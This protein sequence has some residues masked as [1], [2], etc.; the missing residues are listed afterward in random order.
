MDL[1]TSEW[2]DCVSAGGVP[3][4]TCIW[5]VLQNLINALIVLSGVVAVF[6][7]MYAGYQYLTSQGDQEKVQA[8]RKTLTFTIIGL[9][10]VVFAFFILR[11]IVIFTGVDLDQLTTPP[12]PE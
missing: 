12:T 1:F 4:L 9:V 5:V 2:G 11:F 3:T 10:I 8:A 7:I 6:L